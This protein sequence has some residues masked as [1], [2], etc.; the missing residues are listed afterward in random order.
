MPSSSKPAATTFTGADT[1]YGYDFISNSFVPAGKDEYYLRNAQLEEL[2]KDEASPALPPGR[3]KSYRPLSQEERA[4]L[5][6]NRNHCADW[7]AVLVRDPFKPQLIADCFFAGLVRLG[8]MEDGTLRYHDYAVPAGITRSRIISCDI[9]DRSA[10]HN[11]HYLSHYITG[12]GVI[13]SSI[14]E[15]DTTNHAKF[16]EGIIREG[17][18]ENVRIWIDPLNEAGGRGILPF[19]DLICADAYLWAMYRDD[20]GLMEAFKRITQEAAGSNRG[21]YGLVGHGAVIKHCL[22]IK[23]VKVGDGAY[24]KGANKLKNL[25]IKSDSSDPTQIGEG[26][27]LVNGIVGYGCRVFYGSKAVRFVLGNNCNLKYGARLIHS[28]LGDNST[29]SCC[30]ILNNLVFPFH[31]Q[32]HNNSFLIATM[33]MGQSNLAAGA[34]VGS[35]H[36]SRGNDGEIIAGRGFWPGLS[37]TLKHNCR[38]ASFVLISKGNYPAELHV[39]LPFCLLTTNAGATRRE[40]MPAYW[41]M[42]NMYALE[43]NNWKFRARDKRVFKEQ[44]IETAYLAPDTAAETINALAL[45]EEWAGNAVLPGAPAEEQREAGRAALLSG[46]G[47]RVYVGN[48]TLE[49]SNQPVRILKSEKGYRAYIEMLHYY[50][51]KTLLEYFAA[52]KTKAGTQRAPA[53]GLEALQSFQAAHP[54]NVSFEWVNLGGQL[55]SGAKAAALMDAIRRGD[56]HSWKEIHGEYER[57]W[58]EYPLDKALNAL[59]VLRFLESSAGN[60]AVISAERWKALIAGTVKIRRYIE[61]QVRK[62]KLKD[63]TDPFRM[64]TYRNSSERDAVLGKLE[65]NPFIAIVR[66]ESTAF[67]EMSSRLIP[68]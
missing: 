12:D 31:E 48:R 50:G 43:R 11:C 59:Q 64:I 9:G 14:H 63:Y 16:G 46:E 7:D 53:D 42:Y 4:A 37:S 34:T 6:A 24:I 28:I 57:L 68:Q 65:D 45:L 38:F 3:V 32:H 22:T 62:T 67:F 47:L 61:E 55:I 54:E 35:N 19:L 66:E 10:V 13:L 27:E 44:H 26:V 25:T 30:E 17:E 18:D 39:P 60:G 40:L 56:L 58:Q 51:V 21:Y 41:W 5:E 23:D 2:Y 15:M 29:V 49:R 52:E 20:A 1:R 33:I 36:N 8:A